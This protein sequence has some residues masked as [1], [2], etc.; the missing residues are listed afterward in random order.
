MKKLFAL[1]LI[2][3]VVGSFAATQAFCECPMAKTWK[4]QKAAAHAGCSGKDKACPMHQGQVRSS[5]PAV[6][7]Q[8]VK[9]SESK[10]LKTACPLH[11]NSETSNPD[12]DKSA[13]SYSSHS[14]LRLS[15]QHT[16]LRDSVLLI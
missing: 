16:Y 5:N 10:P 12:Q 4:S 8:E 15:K 7:N 9:A 11:S 14:T 6:T 2:S 3:V 1:F 13:S